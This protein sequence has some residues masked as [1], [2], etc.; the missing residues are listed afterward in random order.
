MYV[1]SMFDQNI[2]SPFQPPNSLINVSS[3]NLAVHQDNVPWLT[4]F[5]ILLTWFLD[6]LFMF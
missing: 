1:G 2:N 3:E 6:N 5:L 4:I